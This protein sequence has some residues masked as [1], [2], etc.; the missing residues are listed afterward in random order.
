[1]SKS[2][3]ALVML[4][5]GIDS[6]TCL[7][8]AKKKFSDVIAITFNYHGR[9]EN[10][11]KA[12]AELARRA[13]VR[14]LLEI[15]VPFIK[16]YSDFY[17]SSIFKDDWDRRLS[18]YIPARNMIF[19]SICAYYAEFLDI[20]WIV[21]GH[22]SH[23]AEFFKDATKGYIKKINSL[24]RQGGLISSNEQ[25]VILLPLADM[26]RQKIISLA[27]EIDVPLELTWSCHNEGERHCRQ[28]YSC[29]QRL[30]AFSCL[31]IKDP[32]FS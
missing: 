18:S 21:G 17:K 11:K 4:S 28:C 9:I 5:G 1:M 6:S 13:A 30:D 25:P 7:Y 2:K 3:K 14:S 20:K 26:D 32:V 12:T 29:S 22:N 15:N 16:E 19:Y 8:W 27:L 31:G 24:L 23:D 10:E